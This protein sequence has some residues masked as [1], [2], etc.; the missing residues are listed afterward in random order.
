MRKLKKLGRY[1]MVVH[2][3]KNERGTYEHLRI[4]IWRGDWRS[5]LGVASY[6]KSESDWEY[7]SRK[8]KALIEVNGNNDD[9]YFDRDHHTEHEMTWQSGSDAW[10]PDPDNHP[11][12]WY[13][14]RHE[15]RHGEQFIKLFQFVLRVIKDCPPGEYEGKMHPQHVVRALMAA[16]VVPLKYH[17]F[18]SYDGEYV[19][20]RE[21][22]PSRLIPTMDEVRAREQAA[23]QAE[24]ITEGFDDHRPLEMDAEHL[25]VA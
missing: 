8:L 25:V 22:D 15:V 24:L 5:W 4:T 13:G 12:N 18:G 16:G 7:H 17:T 14:F 9:R 6:Y 3:S 21:F 19:V 2:R 1:G 23:R 10:T 11:D 20:D